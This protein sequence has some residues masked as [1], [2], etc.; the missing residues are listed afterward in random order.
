MHARLIRSAI[1][2][3]AILSLISG[4]FAGLKAAGSSETSGGKIPA[5]KAEARE[6]WL[7]TPTVSIMTGFIYKPGSPYTVQQWLENLGNKFDAEQW[8]RDFKETGATHLVFYDKWHDG[9][10]FHDTKT[11]NFK[12]RRDFVREVAAACRK[13]GLKLLIYFNAVNDGNP[14]FQEWTL[15]KDGKPIVRSAPWRTGYQTLHSPFREKCLEQVRE[16]L[17]YPIDGIWHDIFRERVDRSNPWMTRGYERMYG[18]PFEKATLLRLEEFNARTLAGYLDEVYALRRER[19]LNGLIVTANGSA[20]NFLNSGV[21]A[22][23]VGSRLHYLFN[24]G[25]SFENNDKLARLAWVLPKPVE[26]N[27]LLNSSWFT[28]LED[29]PPP[30]RWTEKQALAASAIVVCQGAGVHWALAP[31]HDGVFGDDLKHAKLVGA[32]FYRVKPA[33]ENARPYAD[34]GIVLGTPAPGGPWLPASNQLWTASQG[35]TAGA[36]AGATAIGDALARQGIFSRYLF[37]NSQGGSWPVSLKAFKAILV[38]EL[39]VLDE[40]HLEQLR[41][42]VRDGGKLV[43]F[44]HATVLDANGQRRKDYGLSDVLGA[45]LAGEVE[46]PPSSPDAPV[47]VRVTDPA[48]TAIFEDATIKPM[49]VRVEPVGARV[50]ASMQN[51]TQAAAILKHTFGRGEAWLIT[52]GDGAITE[53]SALWTGVTRLIGGPTVTVEPADSGR[54]RIILTSVPGGHALHLIDKAVDKPDYT[55]QD[56]TITLNAKRL[57]TPRQARLIGSNE[58]VAVSAND[59]QISFSIKPD[60]VASVM[61]K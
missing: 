17:A 59:G 1:T 25:H 61:L 51:E 32:W 29:T 8:V 24:E 27:L 36:W 10:V 41:R 48:V 40:A 49:A 31:G 37:M 2:G 57:D 35:R 44:G 5:A 15:D 16:L 55:A 53:D 13:Q 23:L 60:P 43:A 50:V 18:E 14:E 56:V 46:F 39:A 33:L 30:A 28:P 26:V 52:T 7:R 21:W 22:D 9:L 34:V 47:L 19:K 12:S 45:R 6:C 58:V 3:I 4:H 20:S 42:Y 38:P 11:T 54:Y